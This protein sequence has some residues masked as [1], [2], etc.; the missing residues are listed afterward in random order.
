MEPLDRTGGERASVN[1]NS[2]MGGRALCPSAH[3]RL[4]LSSS[5][6]ARL[7]AKHQYS[8]AEHL[9]RSEVQNEIVL[10]WPTSR[11]AFAIER[12]VI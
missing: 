9:H 2:G 7:F 10:T 6:G 11:D 3:S 5:A 8:C 4:R 1:S 12:G